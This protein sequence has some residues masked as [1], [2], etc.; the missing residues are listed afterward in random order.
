MSYDEFKQLCRKSWEE[1][2]SYLCGDRSTKTVKED[3][4][5]VMN[6]KTL[7]LNVVVKQ[8]LF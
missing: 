2:Y 8:N 5:F 4:V 7:I 6:S 3:F 1:D